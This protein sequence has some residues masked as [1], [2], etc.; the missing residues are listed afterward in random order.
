MSISLHRIT[1]IEFS[2][3][4]VAMLDN[5]EVN[6]V[7]EEFGFYICPQNIGY[8]IDL[9]TMQMIKEKLALRVKDFGS[10][11]I[12]DALITD[13]KAKGKGYIYFYIVG[14]D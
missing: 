6:D 9:P 4:P 1:T 10:I 13:A 2:N 14:E 8:K 7:F 12:I 3:A 5:V 11:H